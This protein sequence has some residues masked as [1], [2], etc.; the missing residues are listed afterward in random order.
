[1]LHPATET[2]PGC[3]AAAQRHN[4]K[5]VACGLCMYAGHGIW[6]LG[7]TAAYASTC[8]CMQWSSRH[9]GMKQVSELTHVVQLQHL[10]RHIQLLQ[11]V[12][13]AGAVR[14]VGLAVDDHLV[15][16]H[17]L[18]DLV[19]LGSHCADLVASCKQMKQLSYQAS[20]QRII[21]AA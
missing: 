9:A 21:L 1:M 6:L 18:V 2:H 17:R 19:C 11:Q 3:A 8:T 15:G 4:S 16:G 12:L 20:F 14:A 13:C 7:P 10:G 5:H